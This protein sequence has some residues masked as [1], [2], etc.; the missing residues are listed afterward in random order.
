MENNGGIIVEIDRKTIENDEIYLRQ[1]SK[2]VDFD[3]T[4]WKDALQ[5]LEYFCKNDKLVI[6]MAA[7]QLGI[8][9]RLLYLKKTKL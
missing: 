3:T 4:E 8:P 1:I 9:L 7:V 6:A 5:K 2:P